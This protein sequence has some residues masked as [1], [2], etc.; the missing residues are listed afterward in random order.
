MKVVCE[1]VD[2]SISDATKAKPLGGPPHRES[3]QTG[4]LY[5]RTNNQ[6][7]VKCGRRNEVTGYSPCRA[8]HMSWC[9]S[10]EVWFD[11]KVCLIKST[12]CYQSLWTIY[13]DLLGLISYFNTR[14][15]GGT[16]GSTSDQ[17]SEGCGFEAY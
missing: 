10:A 12:T 9:H 16:T 7:T 15:L 3:H 5:R 11:E 14:R 1:R 8:L 6:D 4:L 13:R 17:R 2:E